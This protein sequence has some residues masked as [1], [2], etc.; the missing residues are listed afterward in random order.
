MASMIYETKRTLFKTNVVDSTPGAG[1]YELDKPGRR[2]IEGETFGRTTRDE[3]GSYLNPSSQKNLHLLPNPTSYLPSYPGTF[4]P[5]PFET[6]QKALPNVLNEPTYRV[7]KQA[8]A[9]NMSRSGRFVSIGV[10]VGEGGAGGP[11]KYDPKPVAR[12]VRCHGFSKTDRPD[13]GKSSVPGPG[14]YDPLGNS[15]GSMP[16]GR[17]RLQYSIGMEA[18]YARGYKS[19]DFGRADRWDERPKGK[20][21][22]SD[23]D[24]KEDVERSKRREREKMERERKLARPTFG[25]GTRRT[26]FDVK[27]DTPGPG[28]YNPVKA[29]AR[30]T[31]NIKLGHKMPVRGGR[32][33]EGEAV[34]DDDSFQRAEDLVGQPLIDDTGDEGI[35]GKLRRYRKEVDAAV[36]RGG[37]VGDDDSVEE[38]GR[39]EELMKVQE[40]LF[41]GKGPDFN[42]FVSHS[43]ATA[44]TKKKKSKKKKKPKKKE[45]ETGPEVYEVDFE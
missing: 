30:R 10:K 17:N 45:E 42:D 24:Y 37:V 36:A 4:S 35:D 12:S 25:M 13:I 8:T 33:V 23:K 38:A 11:G 5:P 14:S 40:R 19:V 20:G 41:F 18:V 39:V 31:G 32:G 3:Y 16:V 6:L 15:K 22:V 44:T 9:S 43:P 29:P 26:A 28:E 27:A 7:P 2:P 21:R 34:G 1:A